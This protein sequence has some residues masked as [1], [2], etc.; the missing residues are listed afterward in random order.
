[1]RVIGIIF[2]SN[3]KRVLSD[4]KKFLISLLV[5]VVTII[6]AM[7]V[8]YSS[9]PSINIGV[10]KNVNSQASD[11]LV[12]LL[13]NTKGVKVKIA[14]DK[15]IKTE[16]ILGKYDGV[17]FINRDFD[18]SAITDIGKY[19]KFYN[20]KDSSTND[21]LKG[22]VSSYLVS[23][24]PIDM[25]STIAKLQGQ[26]LSKAERVISFLA[27]VL[28]ISAVVNAAI[29]IKD[30]EENTFN[31]F[32]YSPNKGFK[33]ILGNVLYNYAFTYMQLLIAIIFTFILGM[34]FGMS[35]LT[36][37]AYAL[38]LTLLM[39]TFGTFI[40]SIFK[41]ELYA[42]MFAGAISLVLSLVGGTFIIYDR[43][44]KGLQALSNITPNRWII[45]SVKYLEKGAA[46]TVNPMIMLALFCLIFSIAAAVMNKMRKLEFR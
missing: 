15:F 46:G 18:K 24:K 13:E 19:F 10:V 25:E 17:I 36:L 5:P 3:F 39:T 6:L 28:L 4:K 21:M 43:M 38:L 11:K 41:K 34:D 16:T 32:M 45:E 23:D 30:R 37:L 29:M 8:N 40:A 20:V 31:R 12:S 33:Y 35:S 44:P 27:T 22:L 7:V 9:S 26:T 42:N 2:L 1:M 14:E